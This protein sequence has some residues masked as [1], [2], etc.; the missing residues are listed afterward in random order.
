M[1]SLRTRTAWLAGIVA[2]AQLGCAT[3]QAARLYQTGTEALDRGDTGDAIAQ[4]ERAAE[5]APGA[6][7]VHNH[8]GLAYWAA[9]RNDEARLAFRQAVDLDCSNAA[10]AANLRDAE[11]FALRQQSPLLDADRERAVRERAR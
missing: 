7:A 2:I 6:S 11:A 4:L 9:G 3:F 5:L 8:L 1:R 10:A